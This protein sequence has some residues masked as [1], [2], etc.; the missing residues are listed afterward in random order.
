MPMRNQ[1]LAQL[2]GET[3]VAVVYDSDISINY[4]P[5]TGNLQ[6]ARYGL[7]HFR[8][9]ALEVAG[10]IPENKSD[11]S[12]HGLWLRVLGEPGPGGEPLD[13]VEV[14]D[15]EPDAIEITRSRCRDNVLEVIGESDWA[16]GAIMKV[17]VDGPD[18]GTDPL[19]DPFLTEEEMDYIGRGRY[20]LRLPMGPFTESCS[21]L[22]KRR[23]S[24]D[25]DEGGAYND[26]IGR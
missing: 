22:T 6:G 8:V 16:P 2:V 24:I 18:K 5:L 13:F 17:S 4:E 23:L 9:E 14:R 1:D 12:F 21:D 7:F 3:C 26:R 20:R 15:H 25:T 19:V 10:S 11:T